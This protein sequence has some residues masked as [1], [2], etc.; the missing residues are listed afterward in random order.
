MKKIA[1]AAA[2]MLAFLTAG[3]QTSFDAYNFSKTNYAGTA[4]SMALGNAMTALGGDIG[5]IVLNPAGSAV[6]N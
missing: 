6:F 1:M 3:A 2:L 4:R 5:A